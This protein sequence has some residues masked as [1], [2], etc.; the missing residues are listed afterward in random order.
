[1]NAGWNPEFVF[2]NSDFMKR[3]Y[4][5]AL[6]VE[7]TY[8]ETY[9]HIDGPRIGDVVE[10]S[11]GFKVFEHA[12]ISE[13][14]YGGSKFGMLCICESGSSWTNGNTF[15]TSG[16]AFRGM[17][18][19]KLTP[20]GEDKIIVWTW[21]CLGSGGGQGIYFPLSVRKWLIPYEPVKCRSMV[22]IHGKGAKRWDGSVFPAVVIENS[23]SLYSAESFC[24]INAFLAWAKY[25]GFKHESFGNG[26]FNRR[27]PQRIE[28][29]C[30]TDPE[31]KAPEGAKPIKIVRNGSLKDGW[32]VTTDSTIKYYWPNLYEP[33]KPTDFNSPEYKKKWAELQKYSGN[34]L[35]V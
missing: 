14:H 16:G 2:F 4:E 33:Y 7:K 21:G 5:I 22:T 13:N 23:G 32:V 25:V 20:A 28:G 15:S 31:W 1:M 10:F 11:D 34:P 8:N 6:K 3:N 9:G 18:M 35:G 19:S 12:Q 26:T 27:S 24:S 30:Y 17:H 29:E